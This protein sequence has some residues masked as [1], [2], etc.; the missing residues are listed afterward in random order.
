MARS[1]SVSRYAYRGNPP[2][3]PWL[4]ALL[5]AAAVVGTGLLARSGRI[6]LP[7]PLA[8][9]QP[10]APAAAAGDG[11]AGTGEEAAADPTANA[12][13][14]GTP[15]EV[16]AEAP[17]EEPTPTGP[18]LSPEQ[19]AGTWVA[20]WNGGDYVGLYSLLTSAAKRSI[21]EDD[22]VARYT[23]IAAR[24]GL[25]GV[26]AAVSGELTPGR[27]VPYT[28]DFDS[29][30][31]GRFSQSGEVP[32]MRE[33]GQWRVAWTPSLIFRELG[34]DGCVDVDSDPVPRGTI[35]DREGNPLAYDGEVQRVGVVPGQIPASEKKRVL[36]ALAKLTG[37]SAAAL[38]KQFDAADPG[39][40][41]RVKDFPSERGPELLNVISGLPG[42]SVH[43]ATAR[44]YPLGA[45]AAAVTGYVQEATA[46]QLAADPTLAPGQV[47]GQ[48][49]VEAG[50]DD[51]LSGRPAVRL[52]VVGC[53]SRVERAAIASRPA[54]AANDVVL[55]IDA[56]LQQATA[57]AL[58]A[59]SGA[60][61][62]AVV[63]DPESGAV[64]AMASA[65]SYD[66]NGFALGFSD[67]ERARLADAELRPLLNRAAQAAY[68][69]GS[70]FKVIPF[71]AA[72]EDL[73][74]TPQ[75]VIDCPSTFSLPGASQVWQDWT[76]EEGLGPQGPLTL[77]QALVN[78]CNTVFYQLGR[79]LDADDP[80]A[81]PRMA[82]AFGLG[83]AT[84]IPYLPEV[85]GIVPDP[86]WKQATLGDYWATG[87]AVNL[88]IGQGFLEATPLQMATAYAAIANGGDL[89][90]PY[91]VSAVVRAGNQRETVGQRTVRSRLPLQPSTIAALQD[92]LHDQTSDWNGAGSVRVFGDFPWPI[93]GK[94]GTAQNQLAKS[95]KPHSWFAAFGPY[96]GTPTIASVVMFE[97]LGEGVSYAAPATKAIYE[98]YLRSDLAPD[99]APGG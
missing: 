84:G 11:T 9:S 80:E 62:S 10:T 22:F 50:A 39:W 79:D 8:A 69:T 38:Q 67:A 68:P 61:G 41:V 5:L 51:L 48:A 93:A 74:D 26:R 31:V 90:E 33:N 42:V 71:A 64:L 96:G 19:I 59:Q 65:P 2:R 23:G 60:K 78:S 98:A 76:V 58:A 56:D 28:V 13:A 14:A 99:G 53:A 17:T 54:T 27:S 16:A 20:R 1:R 91:V 15:A 92:A 40:F 21:S 45:A 82:R 66:P 87:D 3:W 44:V 43:R 73:G 35:F 32:L 47:V 7:G 55:T 75:T 94:T 36:A 95:Q 46:E 77:H 83:A 86:A 72:I 81:L 97:N 30:L 18:V 34:S 85:A 4:L 37:E 52:V 24:A 12:D 49:G 63:L 25:T 89:L 70:I 88:A 29:S 57:A 6:D